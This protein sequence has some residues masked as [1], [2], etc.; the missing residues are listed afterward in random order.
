[1]WK[2]VFEIPRAAVWRPSC[3][4]AGSRPGRSKSGDL[5]CELAR[6]VALRHLGQRN[7][8]DLARVARRA[9]L[10]E[11]LLAQLGHRLHRRL[12]I[13]ARVELFRVLGQDAADL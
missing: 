4:F 11:A 8:L 9:E 7:G 6:A 5:R 3:S 12:Q 2:G 1:M 13:L 10:L